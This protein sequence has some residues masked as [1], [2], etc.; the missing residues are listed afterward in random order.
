PGGGAHRPRRGIQGRTPVIGR[1]RSRRRINGLA[2]TAARRISDQ[3]QRLGRLWRRS[4]QLRVVVST[5]AMSLVV[6]LVL[7]YVL[8]SQITDRMLDAKV[9]AATEEIERARGTV[10]RILDTSDAGGA[11]ENRLETA[12]TV[13][14]DPGGEGA[15]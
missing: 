10:D 12:K 7:G 9:Q 8:S 2:T 11:L 13:L 1:V 5:L 3:G 4:L 14:A 15:G 6:I